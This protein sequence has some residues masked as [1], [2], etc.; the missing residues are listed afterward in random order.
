VRVL[1]SV[2][3]VGVLRVGVHGV[4]A[5]C[6][7]V[8][9]RVGAVC[10]RV[11]VCCMGVC[12]CGCV[13]WI[14]FLLNFYKQLKILINTHLQDSEQPIIRNCP[15]AYKSLHRR[16]VQTK[17]DIKVQ[18]RLQASANREREMWQ[19]HREKYPCKSNS[20]PEF[21]GTNNNNNTNTKRLFRN[22]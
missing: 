7:W 13:A 12:T 11:G 9:V 5:C 21:S 15:D 2:V 22:W 1:C 16:I 4:R 19:V 17:R 6:A 18:C 14:F 8:C 10:V 3:C 20:L